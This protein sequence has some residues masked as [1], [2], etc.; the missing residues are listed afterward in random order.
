MPV[1]DY[2]MQPLD[3]AVD[4][5]GAS[6]GEAAGGLHKAEELGRKGRK[7][8]VFLAAGI[9]V[10]VLVGVAVV[11]G[12]IVATTAIAK[13]DCSKDGFISAN[14]TDSE[15]NAVFL[16]FFAF[17]KKKPKYA[18]YNFEEAKAECV[19]RDAALWEVESEEEWEAIIKPLKD[20]QK[21][22]IWLNGG[23]DEPCAVKG[24]QVR[25]KLEKD[26]E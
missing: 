14:F 12:V 11:A 16:K 10:L 17:E 2:P 19:T 1:A 18:L 21:D 13:K 15:G 20:E 23:M 22:D 5:V 24:A 26:F 3:E 8:A 25:S 9:V 4:D 6:P 7:R